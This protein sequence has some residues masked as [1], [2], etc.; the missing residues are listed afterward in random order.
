MNEGVYATLLEQWYLLSISQVRVWLIFDDGWLAGDGSLEHASERVNRR[1]L[2]MNPLNDRRR[3][4]STLARFLQRSDLLWRV[5]TL[6]VDA[7][8]A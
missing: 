4:V 8:D 2:L 7:F 3:V 5:C 1:A 6:R